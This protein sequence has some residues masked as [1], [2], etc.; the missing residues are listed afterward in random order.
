VLRTALIQ[1]PALLDSCVDSAQANPRKE[2]EPETDGV[3][4]SEMFLTI[5]TRG[6]ESS[7]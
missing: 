3:P 4:D 5:D 6:L 7:E 1:A 2:A